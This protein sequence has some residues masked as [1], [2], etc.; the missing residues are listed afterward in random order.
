MFL[1]YLV[2]GGGGNSVSKQETNFAFG[3]HNFNGSNFKLETPLYSELIIQ[4]VDSQSTASGP[5]SPKQ[6]IFCTHVR[7]KY[8][9]I[10]KTIKKWTHRTASVIIYDCLKNARIMI[11]TSFLEHK[12]KTMMINYSWMHQIKLGFC[13]LSSRELMHVSNLQSH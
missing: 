6:N 7:R 9:I 2:L 5:I 4:T 13:S 12:H 3:S 1:L 10:S 8:F 11:R